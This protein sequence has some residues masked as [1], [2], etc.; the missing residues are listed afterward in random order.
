MPQCVNKI[1]LLTFCCMNTVIHSLDHRCYILP[2]HP[3]NGPYMMDIFFVDFS[4]CALRK[5]KLH[6]GTLFSSL[7]ECTEVCIEEKAKNK[8]NKSPGKKSSGN[9]KKGPSPPRSAPKRSRGSGKGRSPS[10]TKR[11]P[12]SPGRWKGWKLLVKKSSNMFMWPSSCTLTKKHVF[13]RKVG[14]GKYNFFHHFH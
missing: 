14:N 13:W 3:G 6:Y 8:R 1:I 11:R 9:P 4:F 5:T 12:G 7:R 10:P 2:T